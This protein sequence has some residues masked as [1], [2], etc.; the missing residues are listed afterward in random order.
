MIGCLEWKP[1]LYRWSPRLAAEYDRGAPCGFLAQ[2]GD[3]LF[4]V[5]LVVRDL[6]SRLH[7]AAEGWRDATSAY[8][9]SSPLLQATRADFAARAVQAFVLA[10][11]DTKV[12]SCFL[13]LHPLIESDV[14]AL[15][16]V[17]Q[18]IEHGRT[19]SI[20]LTQD[21]DVILQH[22]RKSHRR[23][24]KRGAKCGFE[25]WEDVD[26]STLAPF[27]DLYQ[28]A[29]QRRGARSYYLFSREFFERLRRVH[30]GRVHLFVV[31]SIHGHM[32]A[33]SI[34]TECRGI[35]TAF[36]GGTHEDFIADSP[37]KLADQAVCAWAKARG[38]RVFHLGGGVG[39]KEDSLFQ[40]KA[41][42][43]RA[44]HSFRTWHII[45]DRDIYNTLACQHGAK[46]SS[47]FFPVY[48]RP[49]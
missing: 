45:V 18:V 37:L 22:M 24:L 19:V 42:F 4:F 20:D 39:A 21:M 33:A 48:R 28:S 2:E 7:P 14:A 38:N 23:D 17:G 1:A 43:S 25:A 29:M 35:V 5:P 47:D 8:G 44:R 34:Y 32:A 26:W 15:T 6:D 13:R 49:Q 10:L 31:R 36:L 11:R 16:G 3:S 12:V 9:Y 40:F 27:L 30:E 46:S 41:G